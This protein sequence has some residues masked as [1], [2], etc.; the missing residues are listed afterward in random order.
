MWILKGSLLGI[1][2]FSVLFAIRFH[3]IF[4]HTLIDPRV[5][6]LITV[7]S[8][9]FWLGLTGCVLVGCAIVGYWPA[10]A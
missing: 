9:F 4:Y 10:K 1:L 3:R 6:W 5:I 8:V 7:H 2:I